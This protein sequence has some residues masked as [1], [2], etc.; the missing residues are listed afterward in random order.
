MTTIYTAQVSAEFN[1]NE[2]NLAI[3]IAAAS[4]TTVKIKQIRVMTDDGTRVDTI[5]HY[6]SVKLVRESA[7]GTGG[8]SYTPIKRD[9]SS[10][11]SGSTVKTGAFVVGT[12]SETIDSLSVHSV[13][14]FYWSAA[15]EEDKI[16][17]EP[18]G[19]FGI[20]LNPAG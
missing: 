19:I 11:A 8:S 10:A 4:N 12:V 16:T 15:D 9:P 6:K 1:F 7:A 3:E 13:T 20:V 2:D 5:D 14:D 18:G 17:V